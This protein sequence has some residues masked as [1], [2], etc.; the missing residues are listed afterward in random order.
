MRLPRALRLAVE[1]EV[2]R[3]ISEQ[4]QQPAAGRDAELRAEVRQ[5]VIAHNER[6]MRK[7]QEPLDVE[8]EIDRQPRELENLGQATLARWLLTMDT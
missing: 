5:L 2:S 1:A 7:G 6:R 3:L 4:E 8:V